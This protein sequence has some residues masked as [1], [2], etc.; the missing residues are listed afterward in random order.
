[1]GMSN[2]ELVKGLYEAFR[3]G[4]VPAVLG[5]MDPA[6]EWHE[7]ESNPYGAGGPFIGPDAVLQHV[8]MKLAADWDG[9]AVHPHTFHDAGDTVIVEL[10]Y[11][12]TFKATGAGSD[13]QA[14]HVWR[15]RNGKVAGFQQYVD[16]ARLKELMGGHGT[17]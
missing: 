4:D 1:M 7:A 12:G 17:A 13:T 9:F 10:R 8:F 15:M 6:V 16:T 5:A 11:S 14:C 3:Q 2:V